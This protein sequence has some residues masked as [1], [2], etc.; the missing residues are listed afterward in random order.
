MDGWPEF[1]VNDIVHWYDN[2]GEVYSGTVTRADQSQHGTTLTVQTDDGTTTFT[3]RTGQ[4]QY[5]KTGHRNAE[6]GFALLPG[7]P[8]PID[9]TQPIDPY[10]WK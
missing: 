4:K 5:R 10:P 2:E 6:P 1:K 3:P 7:R 9:A 8:R